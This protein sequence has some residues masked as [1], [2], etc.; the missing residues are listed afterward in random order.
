MNELVAVG[1]F[2][3][4]DLDMTQVETDI[5]EFGKVG[6]NELVKQRT[7]ALKKSNIND[8]RSEGKDYPNIEVLIDLLENGVKPFMKE[9]FIPNGS[10]RF[11][12]Q[13]KSYHQ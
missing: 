6:L 4:S 2:S 13:S 1:D 7:A 9:S 11:Y 3:D 10:N 12:R 8:I 5:E